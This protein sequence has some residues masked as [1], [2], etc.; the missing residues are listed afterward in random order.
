MHYLANYLNDI[1]FTPEFQNFDTVIKNMY[2]FQTLT[3]ENFFQV[4]PYIGLDVSEIQAQHLKELF[5][6]FEEEHTNI[7]K[8]LQDSDSATTIIIDDRPFK[9]FVIEL[10]NKRV[11]FEMFKNQAQKV[12]KLYLDFY[13]LK[14]QIRTPEYVF[15]LVDAY[16]HF[17]NQQSHTKNAFTIYRNLPKSVLTIIK[18]VG[19]G[20]EVKELEAAYIT[21][22]ENEKKYQMQIMLNINRFYHDQPVESI[23]YESVVLTQSQISERYN[24]KDKGYDV[25]PESESLNQKDMKN[26]VEENENS[27]HELSEHTTHLLD[28]DDIFDQYKQKKQFYG[29]NVVDYIKGYLP[30][31]VYNYMDFSK[32]ED[33]IQTCFYQN[34]IEN[35]RD[36]ILSKIEKYIEENNDNENCKRVKSLK[37]ELA[38]F[39]KGLCPFI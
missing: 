4:F 19:G 9:M 23:E 5:L 30:A 39:F 21:F 1:R 38:V 2:Y 20:T 18:S 11:A 7:D 25:Q 27:Q 37:P 26:M 10:F 32:I 15:N 13:D 14:K 33:N 36:E 34:C 31:E 3:I 28:I 17:F 8:Y 24:Q 35:L 12:C 16:N 29:G 6:K 22:L